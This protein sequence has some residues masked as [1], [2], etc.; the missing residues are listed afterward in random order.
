[1]NRRRLQADDPL[2]VGETTLIPVA[3]VFSF[4]MVQGERA[5]F[6]ARKMPKAVVAVGPRGTAALSV[7][8]EA[9]SLKELMDE[10]SGLKEL[11]AGIVGTE[12]ETEEN[13]G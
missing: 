3:E 7:E 5:A 4:S 13:K 2:T 10:V 8:G 1:M 11:V 9:V 12:P 6:A